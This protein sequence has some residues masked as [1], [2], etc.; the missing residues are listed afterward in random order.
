MIY[1]VGMAAALALA[2]QGA[3]AQSLEH[4][5][6]AA[7]KEAPAGTRFGLLVVD[8]DGKE[9]AAVS[10]DNRF[11]PASNTKLYTTAAAYAAL[12]DLTAPDTA[13]TTRV[14]LEGR[15]VVL[16]GGGDARLSSAADC[17]T[18]C[19]ATLADAVAARTRRVHDVI[20]DDSL[21]PDE[22]W[23]LGMSWNN[24]ESR[25]GTANSALTLDDNEVA[26]SVTPGALGTAP[27][28]AGL[29]Y[30]TVENLAT[31][32]PGAKNELSS[33]RAPNRMAVRLT[34]TI[35]A[36]ATPQT[37]RLSVDD[38]A[39]YAAWRL[40]ALLRERGVRVDGAVAVRHRPLSPNDDPAKRGNAPVV[41]LP[42]GDALAATA[43]GPLADDIRTINKVSQNL[44]AELLLRRVGLASGSGS[45]ADG[46]ARVRAVLEAAGVPRTA[47]DF[48]DGS[49]MSTYNRVTP[50][51]TV[52]LLRWGAK[53][54]WGAAWRET[55]PVGGIDGT[56]ARRFK[57]TPLDGKLFAKTGSLNATNGL[58]GYMI[59]KSGR[60]LTFATYANDVPADAGGTPYMDKALLAIADA[61]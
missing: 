5:V 56:L 59:A 52:A 34:G 2:A 35:G 60:T 61:N 11:M 6:D 28:V 19:L 4:R 33:T 49:G 50:R 14:R 12:G 40:R 27:A 32:V 43:P 55:F 3:N 41:T 9:V 46:Q 23:S 45:V 57:G 17:A 53:Q 36:D 10:P 1:R 58:A 39:H 31:T 51:A 13:G 7:L 20:G 47:Y 42:R 37:L 16:V 30:Y 8:E 22:R 21:F 29:G 44:H 15:D 54:P 48:A 25:Y 38:P 26:L 18:D 24:I